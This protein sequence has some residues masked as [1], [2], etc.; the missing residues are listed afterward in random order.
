MSDMEDKEEKLVQ[1]SCKGTTDTDLVDASVQAQ[2]DPATLSKG[3]DQS[4]NPD[5]NG[6]SEINGDD[7]SVLSA[8]DD[9]VM[10][11]AHLDN[12]AT[13]DVKVEIADGREKGQENK[14]NGTDGRIEIHLEA[15]TPQP[16]DGFSTP[17]AQNKNAWLSDVEV[18]PSETGHKILF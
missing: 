8:G 11:D 15:P 3:D 12:A 14:S 5:E 4:Q 17:V 7:N 1:D 6:K 16:V 9:Q 10:L 18:L 13:D 2:E